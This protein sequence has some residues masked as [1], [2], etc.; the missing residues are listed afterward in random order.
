MNKNLLLPSVIKNSSYWILGFLLILLLILFL[1]WHQV[2]TGEGTVIVFSPMDRPQVLH[3]QIEAKIHKWHVKEGDFVNAGDIL[4]ELEELN[5]KYLDENLLQKLEGQKL[6]LLSKKAAVNSLLKSLQYQSQSTKGFRE[7]SLPN[8]DLQVKQNIDR[9][10]ALKA[11]FEASKQNL[12]TAELN[13]ERREL[14]FQ[15]GLSSKRDLELSQLALAEAKAQLNSSQAELDLASRSIVIAQNDVLRIGSEADF[16]IFEVQAKIANSYE[17][18]AEIDSEIFKIDIEIENLIQRID[19]RIIRSPINGQVTRLM[20]P[21]Q[22]EAIKP[23]DDLAIIV[24][25][26]MDQAVELYIADNLVPLIEPGRQVRLQ[27]SGW[28]SVQFLGWP[29]V[30]IGSFAGIVSVVDAVSLKD[31]KIRIIVKP[32]SN[33]IKNTIDTSWPDSKYLRPGTKVIGWVILD[34]V[35]IWFELWR[36]FSGFQPSLIYHPESK[37]KIKIK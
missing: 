31:A 18:L 8:A 22:T 26:T 12:T 7:A 32:D 29:S 21:G 28:P 37:P 9:L 36:I 17:K 11:K 30:A 19:Q 13:F 3:S 14:L 27:F 2:V 24:P 16:K 20:H 4:L 23:G 33:R 10:Q 1:P 34:K 25:A 5:P 15:K 6:T 35:P